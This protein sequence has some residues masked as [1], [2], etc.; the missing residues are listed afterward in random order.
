MKEKV[1]KKSQVEIDTNEP[2]HV[3]TF[4]FLFSLAVYGSTCYRTLPGGDSAELVTASLELG[5][6]HPPGYPLLMILLHIWLSPLIYIF[7][8]PGRVHSSMHRAKLFQ[9][10]M[11]ELPL[12][13]TKLNPT[14]RICNICFISLQ[15]LHRVSCRCTT[16]FPRFK[17]NR[18]LAS[19]P[20]DFINFCLFREHLG[21]GFESG[22]FY[23]E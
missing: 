15:L 17:N 10:S 21:V 22:G 5:V 20:I 13:N 23:I 1:K 18:F 6:A 11:L 8:A 9:R 12:L 4:I 2:P 3:K 14:N 7:D 19:C 16:V